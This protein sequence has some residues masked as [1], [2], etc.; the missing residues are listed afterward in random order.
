MKNQWKPKIVRF[1]HKVKTKENNFNLE[2]VA[3]LTYDHLCQFQLNQS[4][5]NL[6][7][8]IEL[9]KHLT[10]SAVVLERTGTND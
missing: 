3:T 5:S 1:F 4:K 7:L 2:Q 10:R 6:S 8:S 9:P